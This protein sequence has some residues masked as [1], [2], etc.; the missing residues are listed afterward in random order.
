MAKSKPFRRMKQ[1][2]VKAIADDP[3]HP[4]NERAKR[5]M[6]MVFGATYEVDNGE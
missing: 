5:H 6:N 3:N 1:Y 2:E 4:D